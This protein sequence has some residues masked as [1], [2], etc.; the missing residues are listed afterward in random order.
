MLR[1]VS[2]ANYKCLRNLTVELE[3]FTIL[4]GPN[5]S[6]KSS[7]LACLELIGN[8]AR[9]TT[10]QPNLLQ[11]FQHLIAN[12]FRGDARAAVSI[13]VV[14]A[15]SD[16]LA[17]EISARAEGKYRQLLTLNNQPVQ[18]E[19]PIGQHGN[20]VNIQGVMKDLGIHTLQASQ[21]ILTQLSSHVKEGAPF[22]DMIQNIVQ[23]CSISERFQLSPSKMREPSATA[24]DPDLARDGANLAAVVTALLTSGDLDAV[25]DIS[26]SLTSAIPTL[27]TLS[28]SSDNNNYRSLRY[29]LT[30]PP[31]PLNTI[32]ATEVSDGALYLTAFLI[33]ARTHSF[34]TVLIE[35]PE[36]GLHPERLSTVVSLLRKMTTGEL[37]NQPC[38]II[39]TTHSPLL[40]DLAEPSEI[41]IFQRSDEGGTVVGNM[42][43]MPDIER[44]KKDFSMGEL[45]SS[46]GERRLSEGN[47]L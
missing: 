21:S 16:A 14:P 28:T 5:D 12:A 8:F 35:E 43:H 42:A 10:Q 2:V 39:L 29:T 44:L 1:R 3:P 9:Q 46:F 34:R 30:N 19:A 31:Q 15:E 33:L 24:N 22:Y 6:G 45:W 18:V 26:A 17:F 25:N 37:G 47:P 4:I 32:P 27:K 23:C 40:L 13:R 20:Q 41:R 36:N 7:F 38:Q 11:L